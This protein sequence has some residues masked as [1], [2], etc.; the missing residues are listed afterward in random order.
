VGKYAAPP[1]AIVKGWTVALVP[2]SQQAVGFRRD[3]GARRFAHNW[4]VAQMKQ[5][6]DQGTQAGEHDPA[7]WSAWSLRKRWNA[8][9]AEAAPWW[10]EC[11]KEAFSNGI[12]DAV[13]AL[14]NWHGS[15]TG[16]R[17]GPRVG[18]PR[19]RK[20]GKDR[21]RCTYTTGALRVE[22]PRHIVL[23]GAGRVQTAENIRPIWRHIRRGTG[24]LLAATVSERAG[25]WSVSLRLEISAPW[26]PRA[27]ADTVGVDVGIGRC[28]LTVMRPD[29]TVAA[30]VPNPRA[31]RASLTG[32][33]RANRALSRK[34]EG[35]SRWRKAKRTL[36]RAHARTV[37]IR[38]DAIHKATTDLTKTH[39]QIVIEGLAVNSLMHGLRSHRKSWVDAA[40]G[41]LRRQLTYKSQWYG[42][43]LW[44]ADQ[45]YPSSR[46][47]SECGLVNAGL[48]LSDRSWACPGCCANHDRDENAG[49]NLAR[50]PASQAEAPSDGK[51]VFVRPVVVK[52]VNHLGKVAA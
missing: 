22:G 43:E 42:A 40:A 5:A 19:F 51:T 17:E 38:S 32:L 49:I 20:K 27:R 11:S 15:K 7:V 9:K 33:R 39:G 3:D 29:G 25:R 21:V 31:L 10:A 23:P 16:R 4:A 41:E 28:L 6:F 26:Q 8:V 24:R 34:T 50:L 18:F 36:G 35:S 44:V 47:C 12:A 46:T 13:T 14:K 45:F 1:G 30:R 37:A 48:T 52:R 2:S